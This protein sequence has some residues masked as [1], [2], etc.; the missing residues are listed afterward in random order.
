MKETPR[1]IN[2]KKLVLILAGVVLGM[3]VFA[4]ALVPIYNSLCRT[5]GING[6]PDLTPELPSASIQYERSVNVEFLTTE[7]K[8]LPWTFYPKV[9]KI[10]VHPGQSARIVFFAQN[11]SDHTMV[12]QAIPSI[13]PGTAA[14]YFKKTECFCFTQQTLKA[15]EKMDLSIL[16]HLDPRL[17]DDVHTLTL[18]YTLFDVT[19]RV[20]ATTGENK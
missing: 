17:P 9:K 15:H 14:R 10:T 16:F 2:N 6:K 5:F 12:I 8:S 13:T 18:A 1:K 3:C 11:N 7:N 4:Y 20:K 19:N